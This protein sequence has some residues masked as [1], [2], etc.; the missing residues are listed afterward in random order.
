MPA[1]PSGTGLAALG[2][3]GLMPAAP[4]GTVQMP[5]AFSSTGR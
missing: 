3:S 1:A 5:A 2:G 4:S